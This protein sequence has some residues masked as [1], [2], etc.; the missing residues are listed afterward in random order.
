VTVLDDKDEVDGGGR[1]HQATTNPMMV[2]MVVVADKD[3]DGGRRR[4]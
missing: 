1:W 4:R 2:T 3:G